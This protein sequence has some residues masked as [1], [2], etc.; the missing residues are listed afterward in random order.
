MPRIGWPDFPP[1]VWLATPGIGIP[2]ACGRP[3]LPELIP[4]DVDARK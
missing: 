3:E 1:G 2:V 4:F